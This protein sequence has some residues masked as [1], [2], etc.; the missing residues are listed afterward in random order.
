[1][2]LL[3]LNHAQT[4]RTVV[5]VDSLQPFA[6]DQF[7]RALVVK[8]ATPIARLTEPIVSDVGAAEKRL[9]VDINR[10]HLAQLRSYVSRNPSRK[11]SYDIYWPHFIHIYTLLR[12]FGRS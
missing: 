2:W 3:A 10:R 9:H 4:G 12:C 5:Y 8:R 11:Y 1:L 7:A 6:K